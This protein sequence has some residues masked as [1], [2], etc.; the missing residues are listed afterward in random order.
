MSCASHIR[1]SLPAQTLELIAEDGMLIRRY[2]VSTARNGAGEMHGS[3][4]TPTGRHII[5]AK[6]GG[7]MP[8]YTVFRGRRPNGQIWTPEIDDPKRDWI[9]SRIL[10]LSGTERGINRMG[11]VDTMR[12]FIYI[13]G[14]P[15]SMPVGVAAS[16]GCVRMR[17]ADVIDLFDRVPVYTPVSIVE[18]SI[19]DNNWS[20]L[21]A[22]ARPIRE[23]VFV[24]E[25]HVPEDMEWDGYDAPSRH[26][27]ARNAAG[28][29]IGTGRL[30]PDGHIG[31][32]SVLPEWRSHEVGSALLERLLQLAKASRR[33]HLE[34]HAQTHASHFYS[35]YGFVAEGPE[36]MEAGIPHIRMIRSL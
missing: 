35:R 29:P 4:C 15:D 25:Q 3:E 18:F 36:F 24:R 17:N 19:E 5:R 34:L 7:D 28:L 1:I 32:M 9:L 13:H 11:Q 26:V 12:R 8:A 20:E 14:C 6:I 27:I 23:A 10:W 2:P 21:Q 22:S 30:L 16:H 31:R 33:P